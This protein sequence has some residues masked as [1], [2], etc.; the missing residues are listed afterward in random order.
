MATSKRVEDNARSQ[1]CCEEALAARATKTTGKKTL[2]KRNKA[3][4]QFSP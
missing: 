1:G 4:G 3:G 2:T